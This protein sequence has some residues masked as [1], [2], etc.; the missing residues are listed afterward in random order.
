VL[1]TLL[2]A[3]VSAAFAG[4]QI[5]NRRRKDRIDRF[6]KAA[7]DIRN[8]TMASTDMAERQRAVQKLRQLQ[9]DAFAKLVDEKLAADESFRIFITLT[10]DIVQQL[11]D[12]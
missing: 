9:D 5:F 2:V 10:N 8:A 7:I 11:D 3:S 6:Y 12:H 4:I 1:V